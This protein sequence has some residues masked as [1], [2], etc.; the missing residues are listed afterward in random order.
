VRRAALAALVLS[1]AAP[2][3]AQTRPVPGRLGALARMAYTVLSLPYAYSRRQPAEGFALAPYVHGETGDVGDE[4][5]LQRVEA[6]CHRTGDDA[7][8]CGGRWR[9]DREDHVGFDAGWTRYRERGAS[10]LDYLTA[11][12]RGDAL[13]EDDVRLEYRFGISGLAGRLNRPGGLAGLEMESY[14]LRP[15]RFDAALA[16]A[17]LDGGTLGDFAAGAAYVGGRLES[18]LGWRLLTGPF[19]DLSGPELSVTFRF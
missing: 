14:P 5:R 16:A 9:L 4:Q 6:R 1:L 18:R 19:P 2:A 10:D 12:A 7:G 11:A 15:W 13:R 17:F 8:G 3:A